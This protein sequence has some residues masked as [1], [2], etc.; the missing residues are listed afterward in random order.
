MPKIF[1]I[2]KGIYGTLD[3]DESQG[4]W[5]VEIF[6]EKGKDIATTPLC[7]TNSEAIEVAK[8]LGKKKND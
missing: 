6:D 8:V 7:D 5:Y 2:K 3:Y 4:K 1:T